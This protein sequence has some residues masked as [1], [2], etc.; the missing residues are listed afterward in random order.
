MNNEMSEAYTNQDMQ[1]FE[2]AEKEKLISAYKKDN[3]LVINA[4]II[5]PN[6]AN[7]SIYI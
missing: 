1:K 5:E 2:E 6:D 4:D 7:K 3:H